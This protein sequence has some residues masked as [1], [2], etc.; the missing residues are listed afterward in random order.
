[1]IIVILCGDR[2]LMLR[3]ISYFKNKITLTEE[4]N[5]L[6]SGKKAGIYRIEKKF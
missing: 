6:L 1:V 3:T 4:Y 5:I 2:E